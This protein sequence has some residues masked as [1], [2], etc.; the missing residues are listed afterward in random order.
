VADR[1]GFFSTAEVTLP[2]EA[3]TTRSVT[4]AHGGHTHPS[5]TGQSYAGPAD[6]ETR[7]I[8][9]AATTYVQPDRWHAPNAPAPETFF[10][11]VETTADALALPAPYP[12]VG[13]AAPSLDGARGFARRGAVADEAMTHFAFRAGSLPTI[14]HEYVHTQQGYFEAREYAW[15]LEGVAT[16]YE[17]L[18]GYRHGLLDLWPL[19]GPSP[20]EPLRGGRRERVVYDKGA[21]LCFLLDQRLRELTGGEKTMSDV[22]QA[23]N[24][25][26]GSREPISHETFKEIVAT[27]GGVRL[28][29]WLDERVAEPFEIDLPENL[30]GAY[31]GPE[32]PR[33]TV[34]D[35]PTT[36]GP[37]GGVL[38]AGFAFGNGNRPE[39][40]ELRV[41]STNSAAVRIGSITPT[42]NDHDSVTTTGSGRARRVTL[43]FSGGPQS[44]AAVAPVGV[45]LDPTG[46]GAT[47]LRL[48]G[49]V[50]YEEGQTESFEPAVAGTRAVV[51]TPAPDAPAVAPKTVPVGEPVDLF[52]LDPDPT[53]RYTWRFG[54]SEIPQAVGP[55]VTRRFSLRGEQTVTVTATDRTGDRTTASTTI[56]VAENG[57]GRYGGRGVSGPPVRDREGVWVG[58][59]RGWCSRGVGQAVFGALRAVAGPK[60][61][62]L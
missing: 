17:H 42:G 7:D 22:F 16:F 60:R 59:R 34:V 43:S 31:P 62:T 15:L 35:A 40:V 38:L 23:L 6:T 55:R 36:V 27:A 50:S 19:D 18:V 28:D 3:E 39:S 14:A 29:D 5:P 52:V 21:A 12:T 49:S 57:S 54:D 51:E 45:S 13:Y 56:T 4:L 2:T 46:V 33:P 25:Y 1:W 24:E 11:I 47:R 32:R 37:G 53:L 58:R 44:L 48:T 10:E 26:D 30:A 20:A 41:E 8:T 61:T 9:G